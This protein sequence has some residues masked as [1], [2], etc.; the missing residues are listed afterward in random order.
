MEITFTGLE[1]IHDIVTATTLTI[2]GTPGNNTI[3]YSAGP[4]GGIFGAAAT[5]LVSVDSFETIEF[6]NKTNLVINAGA[7]SDIVN[8]NNSTVPV[9]MV[10]VTSTIT[11][12]LGDPTASDTLTVNSQAGT[13]DTMVVVPSATVQGDGTVDYTANNL[14]D[15]VYTGTEPYQSGRSIG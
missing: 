5:G 9:G 10:A 7:G 12:N 14:P 13:A 4:G 15:V 1:P 11:V 2:N 3:N 6:I 8:I